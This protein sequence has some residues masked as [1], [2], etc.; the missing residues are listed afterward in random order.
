MAGIVRGLSAEE[1]A[2]PEWKLITLRGDPE[3]QG[4]KEIRWGAIKNNHLVLT[5]DDID[6]S[7]VIRAHTDDGERWLHVSST[8]IQEED[9]N[10]PGLERDSPRV[11]DTEPDDD[12]LNDVVDQDIEDD[13][14]EEE[15]GIV[16]SSMPWDGLAA[17]LTGV[18][19]ISRKV[20]VKDGDEFQWSL[21]LVEGDDEDRLLFDI[22]E[23]VIV[24]LFINGATNWHT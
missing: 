12:W 16:Y 7:L 11:G 15:E 6:H 10:D 17:V 9:G 20:Q 14:E 23:A 18:F 5:V 8:I 4:D 2:V 22:T 1:C 19:D 21:L 3:N 13:D 24:F